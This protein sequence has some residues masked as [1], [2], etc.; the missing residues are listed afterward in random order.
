[1][2]FPKWAPDTLV[3]WANRAEGSRVCD[4]ENGREPSWENHDHI[5]IKAIT[6]PEMERVWRSYK[7]RCYKREVFHENGLLV[8]DGIWSGTQHQLVRGIDTDL[9]DS[10]PWPLFTTEQKR[11]ELKKLIESTLSIGS[12]LGMGAL[13]PNSVMLLNLLDRDEIDRTIEAMP[14]HVEPDLFKEL[15]DFW[16][17]EL[18]LHAVPHVL[19]NCGTLYDILD[20]LRA[21]AQTA[22]NSLDFPQVIERPNK[23]NML[24]TKFIRHACIWHTNKFGTPLYENVASL[25]KV[26][27]G[28]SVTARTVIDSFR[29]I[30][31]QVGLEDAWSDRFPYIWDKYLKDHS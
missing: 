19:H 2:D 29:P 18:A 25:V 9:N 15:G 3:G 16:A 27:L 24:T 6:N 30:K 10:T 20:N 7:K 26:F 21:E 5:V 12:V 23:T 22:L 8:N 31:G 4:K 14:I 17:N 11:Q 1:M 13:R 28:E